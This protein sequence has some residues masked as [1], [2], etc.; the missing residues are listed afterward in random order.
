M[1]MVLN[2]KDRLKFILQF[3]LFVHRFVGNVIRKIIVINNKFIC[4]FPETFTLSYY[5]YVYIYIS[6]FNFIV[7]IFVIN[8]NKF[9]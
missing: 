5:L 9:H 3:L 8:F 4:C 6:I 7:A 1:S 2:E